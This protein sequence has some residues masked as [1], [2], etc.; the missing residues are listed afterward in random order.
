MKRKTTT[1]TKTTKTPKN[2]PAKADDTIHRVVPLPIATRNT[3]RASRARHGT[4][5]AA[6]EHAIETYLP[7]TLRALAQLGIGA[8]TT[9]AAVKRYRLPFSDSGLAALKL[10]AEQ[11]GLDATF[12]LKVC[13]A[14]L[15]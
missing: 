12:L 14:C 10:A 2:K 6:I 11:T 5:A 9:G 7:T 8:K 3:L 15:D 1:K 13:V 4:N